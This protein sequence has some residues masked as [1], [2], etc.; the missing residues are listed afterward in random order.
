MRVNGMDFYTKN[1]CKLLA[2]ISFAVNT[3]FVI[4]VIIGIQILVH[5]WYQ[6]IPG[7]TYWSLLVSVCLPLAA[8]GILVLIMDNTMLFVVGVFIRKRKEER[9]WKKKIP[10]RP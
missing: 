2:I 10:C 8:F 4:L 6:D 7:I 1:D 5:Y 3:F 9:K